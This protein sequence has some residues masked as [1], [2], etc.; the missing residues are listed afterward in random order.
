[1]PRA[2]FSQAE[3]ERCIRA[4][5]RRGVPVGGVSIDPETGEVKILAQ[6]DDDG[7]QAEAERLERAFEAMHDG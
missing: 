1:M 2:R 4:M 7:E 5:Q 6:V 3:V